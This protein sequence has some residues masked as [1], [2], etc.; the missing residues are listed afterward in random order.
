MAARSLGDSATDA[1]DGEADRRADAD[2]DQHGG[3]RVVGDQVVEAALG[4]LD[5]LAARGERGAAFRAQGLGGAARCASSTRRADS[6]ASVSNV[7]SDR[8]LFEV[9][10]APAVLDG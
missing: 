7:V 6:S 10:R 2:R 8:P 3:R 1:P 4:L 9:L 5:L